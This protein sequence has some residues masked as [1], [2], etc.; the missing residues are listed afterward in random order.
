V[1]ARHG[2]GE[3]GGPVETGPVD[4]FADLNA[5]R[6]EEIDAALDELLAGRG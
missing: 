6:R 5:I 4:P 1:R 2:G 3:V